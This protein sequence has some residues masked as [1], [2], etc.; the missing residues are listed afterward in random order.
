MNKHDISMN[1]CKFIAWFLIGSTLALCIN[2]P[3]LIVWTLN[4]LFSLG[5]AYTF[6]TYIASLLLFLFFTM[7]LLI[8]FVFLL[9]I[10]H[11]VL[12]NPSSP[13]DSHLP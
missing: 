10:S 1:L 9:K 13:Y 7:F 8:E 4:V 6:K 3:F 12:D 2:F 5:L 11:K